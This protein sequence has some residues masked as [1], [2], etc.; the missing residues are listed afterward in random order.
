MALACGAL[1]AA[2]HVM[3]EYREEEVRRGTVRKC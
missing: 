2:V 3:F 1:F